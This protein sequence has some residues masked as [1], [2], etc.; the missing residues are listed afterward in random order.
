[1]YVKFLALSID[2]IV[3]S[4]DEYPAQSKMLFQ[5]RNEIL[6]PIICR[7]NNRNWHCQTIIFIF[8]CLFTKTK[9]RMYVLTWTS[10]CPTSTMPA[11]S[12]HHE[13]K[14]TLKNIQREKY[15][16]LL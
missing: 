2:F 10:I 8:R 4:I 7:S 14:R 13:K 16:M 15:H 5:V 11:E 9:L 6:R 12:F 1:M 3:R